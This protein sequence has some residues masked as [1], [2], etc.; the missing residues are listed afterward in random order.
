MAEHLSAL[1][2]ASP[3]VLETCLRRRWMVE[4]VQVDAFEACTLKEVQN[5]H[6][7]HRQQV[8]TLPEETYEDLLHATTAE[9]LYDVLSV[10]MA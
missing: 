6:L 1:I 3:G 8:R 5:M 2:A 7:V 10:C 9:K 4:R